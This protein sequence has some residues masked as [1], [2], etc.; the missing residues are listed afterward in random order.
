M[1]VFSIVTTFATPPLL[2][3]LYEKKWKEDH[4]KP[5]QPRASQQHRLHVTERSVMRDE[6]EEEGDKNEIIQGNNQKLIDRTVESISIAAHSGQSAI[7][8]EPGTGNGEVNHFPPI[9]PSSAG[10]KSSKSSPALSSRPAVS[11]SGSGPVSAPPSLDSSASDSVS[12][13]PLTSLRRDQSNTPDRRYRTTSFYESTV[14]PIV[15]E[16]QPTIGSN[17]TSATSSPNLPSIVSPASSSPKHMIR[18]MSIDA[19]ATANSPPNSGKSIGS[20]VTSPLSRTQSGLIRMTANTNAHAN[21]NAA[22]VVEFHPH[23]H[24]HPPLHHANTVSHITS[25]TTSRYHHALQLLQNPKNPAHH[26][27]LSDSEQSF[28]PHQT[29]VV[30]IGDDGMVSTTPGALGLAG[31]RRISIGSGGD[32]NEERPSGSIQEDDGMAAEGGDPERSFGVRA[33]MRLATSH[34]QEMEL[35]QTQDRQRGLDQEELSRV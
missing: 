27:V 15:H 11:G 14:A 6:I 10:G 23:P 12:E 8:G 30:T 19:G 3:I 33:G 26:G 24:S 1:V 35:K 16:E 7:G 31:A 9:V 21:H 18:T 34:L 20:M 13:L 32:D 29:E 28:G 4:P 25:T 17:F 2:W 5:S 22:S